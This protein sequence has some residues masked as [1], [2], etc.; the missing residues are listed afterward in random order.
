[1]YSFAQQQLAHHSTYP[2]TGRQKPTRKR[3]RSEQK[4]VTI[5]HVSAGHLDEQAKTDYKEPPAKTLKNHR[6]RN[7]LATIR[8]VRAGRLDEQAKTDFKKQAAKILMNH[9]RRRLLKQ[10]V[11]RLSNFMSRLHTPH[12]IRGMGVSSKR[13]LKSQ[14]RYRSLNRRLYAL[15]LREDTQLRLTEA[16]DIWATVAVKA[17]SALDR[18]VYDGLQRSRHRI[19]LIHEAQTRIW[20]KQLCHNVQSLGPDTMLKNWMTFTEDVRNKSWLLILLYLL[21]KRPDQALQFLQVLSQPPYVATLKPEVLA[22]AL[23]HIVGLSVSNL[24][25]RRYRPATSDIVPVFTLIFMHHLA[26][27]PAICSED[28]FRNLARLATHDDLILL[29]NLIIKTKSIVG[30][31]TLLHYAN[32]FGMFGDHENALRCLQRILE[33]AS[34]TAAA[35][36]MVARTSFKWSCALILRR[37]VCSGQNYILTTEIVAAY[38]RLGLK[39]D[40]LLYNVI[41]HNAMEAG[42]HSTAFRVYRLLEDKGVQPDSYTYSILLHGCAMADTP[43]L[44]EDFAEHCAQKAMELQN[45][46]VASGYLHYLYRLHGEGNVEELATILHR[47]YAQFFSLEPLRILIPPVS[48]GPVLFEDASKDVS[49][50]MEPSTVALYIM[51]QIQIRK[52][53][54][55][56]IGEVWKLY[57]RFRRLVEEDRHPILVEMAKQPIVWNTFLLA[58]CKKQQFATASQLIKTMTDGRSEGFPEPNIYTWNIFMHAFI[59]HQQPRA[60]VRIYQIMRSRGIQPDQCTYGSLLRSYAKT[61][62]IGKIAEVVGHMEKEQQL[63]PHVLG[64]LTKVRDRKTLMHALEQSKLSKEREQR[65]KQEEEAQERKTRWGRPGLS[66]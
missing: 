58:F 16:E 42:D 53:L 8:Y 59:I 44:F 22:D 57:S 54:F 61:Q 31:N 49:G 66:H 35:E 47:A 48:L 6:H 18:K 4:G 51:L 65:M 41:M 40:I 11:K 50:R 19:K 3:K 28:L 43:A 60:A 23:E 55:A 26:R 25:G 39:L 13:D 5:R 64:I 30:Y 20:V 9:R 46:W 12:R 52:A 37:S 62:N 63:D 33:R 7:L 56:G 14:G 21:D 27:Y 45:S 29:L 38:L 17:F 34:C 32:I 24:R 1:V 36:H 10:E 2:V 15:R